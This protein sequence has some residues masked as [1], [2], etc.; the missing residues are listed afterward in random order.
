M[1]EHLIRLGCLGLSL[2]AVACFEEGTTVDP[3]EGSTGTSTTMGGG[4]TTTGGS[5]S[6]TGLTT[7]VLDSTTVDPT[8]EG[9]AVTDSSGTTSEV[10][11]TDSTTGSESTGCV[12]A[13]DG[14]AC[15]MENTCMTDCGMCGAMATCADDQSYCGLPIGFFNNFGNN[16]QVNGSIQVGYRFEVF[17]QRTVQQLGVIA[18]GAGTNVR[19]AL[20]D[21]DGNGPANRLAQTSEVMLLNVGNNNFDIGATVIQPGDYWVFVHTESMTPLVRTLSF[22][23]EAAQRLGVPFAEGFPMLMGDEN[24]TTDFRYNLYMVV[25]E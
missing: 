19:L 3:T 1:I 16:A 12:P 10:T 23:F 15:G 21:D 22:N 7:D 14:V 2:T 13:C 17:Q 11:A 5:T 25:E 20:Y 6:T 9:P 24:V 8:T 4:S 18:W